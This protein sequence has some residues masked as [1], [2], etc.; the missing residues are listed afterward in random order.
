M[1]D[2]DKPRN[3]DEEEAPIRRTPVEARQGG[4]SHLNLRVLVFSLGT[5]VLILAALYLLFFPIW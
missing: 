4:R 1:N 2:L 5:V 3:D